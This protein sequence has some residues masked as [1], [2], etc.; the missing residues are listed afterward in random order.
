MRETEA[1][2]FHVGYVAGI[3]I[4]RELEVVIQLGREH[5]RKGLSKAAVSREIYSL[6]FR[7]SREEIVFALMHGAE[8]SS[9]AAVTY[10]YNT[11]RERL[12]RCGAGDMPPV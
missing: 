2:R 1:V 7:R 6:I 5:R 12:V 10:Y 4:T 8:L 9:R 11:R 3:V